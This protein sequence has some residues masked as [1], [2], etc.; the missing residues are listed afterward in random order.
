LVTKKRGGLKVWGT[1]EWE[2]Q[3]APASVRSA[4]LF[5]TSY[6]EGAEKKKARCRTKKWG[7]WIAHLN[8]RPPNE[9]GKKERSGGWC[10]GVG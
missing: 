5:A 7:L 8:E 1:E 9:W 10:G 6:V 2:C 4:R 3:H